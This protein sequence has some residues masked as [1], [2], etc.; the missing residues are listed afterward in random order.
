MQEQH[1]TSS[2]HKLLSRMSTLPANP[3]RLTYLTD[4][5]QIHPHCTPVH[6]MA[7]RSSKRSPH[8]SPPQP[9]L[10]HLDQIILR[11]WMHCHLQY[12]NMQ[13][14]LQEKV[15]WQGYCEPTTG[16]WVL[17]LMPEAP[18]QTAQSLIKPKLTE[19]AHNIHAITSKEFL[20][21][22][23]HQCLF[24]PPKRTLLK[25]LE[26]NQFP[27]WPRFM[28]TAVRKYLPESS[29]AT[30]K[31]HMKRQRQGIQ[32]TKVKV[33]KELNRIKYDRCMNPPKEQKDFNQL[34]LFFGTI[35]PQ[36]RYSV[37]QIH[38]KIPTPLDPRQQN[39]LHTL[40]LDN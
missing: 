28:A 27:I 19:A 7:P 4:H 31:G 20:V 21:K 1:A 26:N 6:S 36:S 3:S 10:T 39:F 15:I 37:H 12:W 38:R 16:L 18:K 9:H 11:C 22:F 24:S 35:E 34:F 14:E 2:Y 32:S 5:T 40:W 29:P 23:L 30:D 25:A 17:P 8:H 13:C 33:S